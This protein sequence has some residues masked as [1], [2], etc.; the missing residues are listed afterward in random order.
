MKNHFLN[1]ITLSS[2]TSEHDLSEII[3]L[4]EE[5]MSR[6]GCEIINLK[7]GSFGR[8]LAEKTHYFK[9]EVHIPN[10][11]EWPNFSSANNSKIKKVILVDLE[12][13]PTLVEAL[14][15]TDGTNNSLQLFFP[16]KDFDANDI[17]EVVFHLSNIYNSISGDQLEIT[18][19]SNFTLKNQLVEF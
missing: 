13:N 17:S 15:D 10:G 11:L 8:T 2:N 6:L 16:V 7:I 5:Y 18:G 12:K 3:S 9:A 4:Y 1:I 19:F 14:R